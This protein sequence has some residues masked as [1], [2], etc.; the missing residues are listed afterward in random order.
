MTRDEYLSLRRIYEP[1]TPE[2]IIVAESPPASGLYFYN[3]EGAVTE[4]LLAAL[5][6]QLGVSASTKK[7][8]LRELQRRG[9]F[10]VDATYEPVNTLSPSKRDKVISRDY[11]HL[12]QDL[13]KIVGS[14]STP[15]VL[16]KANVCRMLEPRLRAD[17]FNVLNR[18]RIVYFPS[19]GG[20]T[21]FHSQFREI[22]GT[23]GQLVQIREGD[24]TPA[25]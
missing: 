8:G 11:P 21:Q 4:P 23:S 13:R 22:L 7:D 18:S 10:L 20:Q 1:E 3:P 17:G 14:A 9:W 5:M 25:R 24:G 19:T 2:L 15:I 6:K 16:I 12:Q